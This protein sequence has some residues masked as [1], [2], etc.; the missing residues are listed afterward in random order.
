ME[1]NHAIDLYPAEE[2]PVIHQT[3]DHIQPVYVSFMNCKRLDVDENES[4]L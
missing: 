4:I 3:K 1:M 2:F